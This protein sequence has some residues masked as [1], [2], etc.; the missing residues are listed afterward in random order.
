MLIERMRGKTPIDSRKKMYLRSQD[1]KI[2]WEEYSI[3]IIDRSIYIMYKICTNEKYVNLQIVRTGIR[4]TGTQENACTSGTSINY[5]YVY[6][7]I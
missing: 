1:R 4:N 3:R 6:I 2:L 7:Y 5:I